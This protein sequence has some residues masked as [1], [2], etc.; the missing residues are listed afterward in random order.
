MS[1]TPT[2][3]GIYIQEVPSQV[4]TITGVSTSITAFVGR[5]FRGPVDKPVLIHGI[6][7]FER[8]FGGLWKESEMTYSIYHYFQNG[9]QSAIILRLEKNAKNAV[10]NKNIQPKPVDQPE[11]P[12]DLPFVLIASEEG[13]W[14]NDLI[15]KIEYENEAEIAE[16]LSAELKLEPLLDADNSKPL[17]TL[18]SLRI[19]KSENNK[20]TIEFI[21]NIS[22]KKSS[23]RYLSKVLQQDSH[24]LTLFDTN[25][26]SLRPKE[27]TYKI[28]DPGSDG[29]DLESLSYLGNSDPSKGK[30][31]K[32]IRAL[33]DAD[34][35]NLLCIP[36]LKGE[37]ISVYTMAQE[38]CETR[39]SILIIDSP[40]EWTNASDPIGDK[41]IDSS[42]MRPLK[43]KNSAIFFPNIKSPDPLDDNRIR[44]F[45][46]SGSIAG[47]IA[48]TDTNRGVWKSPAGI[49]TTLNNAVDLTVN[50]TN[51]ENGDL[52]VRGIN[53]LRILPAAGI[54][55]WGARTTRGADVLAD[56][57]KYLAVRRTALFIEE[58]LYRGTQWVV[59]EPNDEKLW[60]QIRLNIGSF[61]HNLFRQGA[62]QGTDPKKAYYVKC[63]EETTTQFDIDR[64]IVNIVVG[65]A[66]LKP[67]EFVMLKIQQITGQETG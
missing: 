44:A 49:E 50:L 13:S 41:G 5:T 28:A 6:F 55:V 48:R 3:P 57:W 39:R 32:G 51:K 66:P 34:L 9:G 42:D 31:S 37:F 17:N 8:I 63:D 30:L 7:E 60:S 27:G 4:K 45:A 56:Q 64:G 29:E 1:L 11:T 35:F 20:D 23:P 15:L 40:S 43:H 21:R 46:P 10:F 25:V 12:P 24:L 65:F 19:S 2:Y 58:S 61:M 26:P 59:F 18:F 54:V 62:F 14:A 52:N 67:A 38:Y 16:I 36:G 47:V 22:T 33:D 53:C